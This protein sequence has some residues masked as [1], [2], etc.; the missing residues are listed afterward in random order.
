MRIL[1]IILRFIFR[2]FLALFAFTILW[3]LSYKFINPPFTPFMLV[4][5]LQNQEGQSI[6]K[7][8]VKME[9]IHPNLPLA[10][11]AAEDQRFFE[12]NGFDLEA[13]KEAV[14]YN[15]KHGKTRGA[16]TISQ[17]TAKNVFLIPS[18]TYFRKGLEVYFT[19]L[20]ELLWSKKRIMEVYLNVMEQG[21]NIYGASASAAVHFS[22][23]PSKLTRSEAALMAAVLTNPIKFK[24]ASP[25]AYVTRRKVWVLGQMSN[26]GGT[27]FVERLYE[28]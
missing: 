5:Y 24:V 25:S 28:N 14:E 2:L 18:R 21:E 1:K 20:M 16:S 10:V 7:K 23:E 3:V 27:S 4:K 9:K 8:W 26:L 6:Q 12:H 22:K 15:K 17:Q 19:F 11:I 13:I